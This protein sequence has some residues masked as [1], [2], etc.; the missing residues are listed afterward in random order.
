[1]AFFASEDPQRSL[2]VNPHNDYLTR[3]L[4]GGVVGLIAFLLPFFWIIGLSVRKRWA[5]SSPDMQVEATA[6]LASCMALMIMMT[7]NPIQ[8]VFCLLPVTF[9]IFQVRRDSYNRVS[10]LPS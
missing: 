7:F 9:A 1:L 8:E 5:N 3:L 6:A 4:G 10:S 2:L